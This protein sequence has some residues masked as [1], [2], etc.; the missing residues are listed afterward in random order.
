[1]I[2]MASLLQP[3]S[4]IKSITRSTGV[5]IITALILAGCS[6]DG[7]GMS[8]FDISGMQ[9]FNSSEPSTEESFNVGRNP[10]RLGSGI[11]QEVF[12]HNA[13]ELAEQKRFIEA[14]VQL[15]ELRDI[16]HR[17]SDGYRA[18]STAMA[19]LALREGDIKA[20]RRISRQLDTS[21]DQPVRVPPAYA[22][23]VSLYRA[24]SQQ[25]LPVNAPEKIQQLRD[26]LLPV[27]TAGLDEGIS[28]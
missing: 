23:V 10:S 4:N 11:G 24:M 14:R 18:I 20:F 9:W 16:Q 7:E 1:M 15:G 2:N 25:S 19:L 22:E 28:K 17:E 13:I 8:G 21:L 27:E 3:V 6:S 26:R 5:G 12:L